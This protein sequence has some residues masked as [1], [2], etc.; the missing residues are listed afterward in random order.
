MSVRQTA[1]RGTPRADLGAALREFTPRL[2]EYIGLQILPVFPTQKRDGKFSTITRA[3]FLRDRDVRRNPGQ[4]YGRDSFESSDLGFACK[5]YGYEHKL[6]DE[7]VE[8]YMSE[9][10]AELESANVA[11]NVILREQEKRIAAALDDV[12]STGFYSSDS[13]LYTDI[14][15]DWTN[16]G[17]KPIDDIAAAMDIGMQRGVR[18]NAIKIPY[19]WWKYLRSNSQILS[20]IQYT[21]RTT[22]A[23]IRSA[24]ASLFGVDKVLWAIGIRNSKPEGETGSYT[25]IWNSSYVHLL[26]V[27]QSSSL[28]EPCI[29]RTFRWDAVVPDNVGVKTYYEEQTE[30]TIYRVKQFS[31]EKVFDPLFG[32]CLKVD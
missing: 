20:A 1:D 15:T 29:G 32:H 31:D 25:G 8:F 13:G 27:A 4:P 9:F 10:D 24:L 7:E 17:A 16:S 30:S 18:F 22:D 23:E 11:L 21:D 19:K 28:A 5:G 14:S 6:P 3:S 2:D 26:Q 12:T